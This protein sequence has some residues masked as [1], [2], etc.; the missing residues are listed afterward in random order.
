MYRIFTEIIRVYEL[1]AKKC[2]LYIYIQI[3]LYIHISIRLAF[4]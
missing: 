4:Y 3:Y 2:P 1:I